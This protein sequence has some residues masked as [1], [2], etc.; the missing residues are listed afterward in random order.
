MVYCYG[1]L[2]GKG[3]PYLEITQ[4]ANLMKRNKPPLIGYSLYAASKVPFMKLR[5]SWDK[6]S[7]SALHI[8]F[9]SRDQLNA[10]QALERCRTYS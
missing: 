6:S 5:S 4:L 10:M 2:L 3:N 1:R 8:F 9:L 7:L